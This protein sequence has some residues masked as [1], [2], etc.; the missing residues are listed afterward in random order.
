M[1][2]SQDRGE[3]IGVLRAAQMVFKVA[4]W[5]RTT[6]VTILILNMT[7]PSAVSCLGI[8]QL[9]VFQRKLSKLFFLKHT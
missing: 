9:A 8:E 5:H 6:P 7:F 1:C 3:D 2:N 4:P